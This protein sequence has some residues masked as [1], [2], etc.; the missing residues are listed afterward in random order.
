[1][2]EL[3]LKIERACRTIELEKVEQLQNYQQAHEKDVL[4]GISRACQELEKLAVKAAA[5]NVPVLITG[6]T[7]TGKNLLA[8]LIHEL[9][10]RRRKPFVQINCAA[11]PENLIESELFGSERGAFTS[12][13]QT[14][15][16]LFELADKG[17]LL[18]DEIGEMPFGLQSKLLSVIE[19]RQIKRLGGSVVHCV[20][21]RLIAATNLE[22]ELAVKQNKLRQDLYFRLNVLRLELPPLRSRLE[23]IAPLCAHFLRQIAPSRKVSVSPN[24]IKR[25]QAYDFPGNIRELRNLIERSLILQEG[26]QIFPSEFIIT[27][28]APRAEKS[29]SD[30]I[31][32]TKTQTLTEMEKRHIRTALEKSDYNLARTAK[33]LGI[34]LS[35][36]K[37][38]VK[39]YALKK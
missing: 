28:T 10:E 7:G 9:S 29:S 24:E 32:E 3:R 38:K 39:L 33:T 19:T 25:L 35:T 11:L 13:Y 6:E 17:T 14:R 36:L 37:R 15:R 31:G 16:G 22:P 34:S 5:T 1:L 21:V 27:N 2:D 18:L 8:S 20:D 26:E 12:S 4:I 30:L 23:D